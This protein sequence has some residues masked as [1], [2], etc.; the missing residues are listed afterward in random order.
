MSRSRA[1]AQFVPV[2]RRRRR[3]S[4]NEKVAIVEES[5]A[6]GS[7][8]AQAARRHA[9]NRTQVYTWAR[10]F[11]QGALGPSVPSSPAATRLIE[12]Q[13][14]REPAQRATPAGRGMEAFGGRI[15]IT[16]ADGVR[17]AICGPVEAERLKQ[18]LGVLRP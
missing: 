5:R 7:S 2:V 17:I 14:S 15:E 11:D 1:V 13:V 10:L 6:V 12:V 16:L 3:R 8:V 9:V 18:V 4:L